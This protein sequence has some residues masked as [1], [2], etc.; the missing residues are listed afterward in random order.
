MPTIVSVSKIDFQD[1]ISQNEIKNFIRDYFSPSFP[2]VNRLIDVFDNGAIDSRNFC[3]PLPF[4]ET[5]KS[6]EESNWDY[7][8]VALEYSIQAI[9]QA[10][11]TAGIEKSEITD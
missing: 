1:R 8:K 11:L 10:L 2:Q 6:F 9:E 4:Y 3:H 7:V 5:L